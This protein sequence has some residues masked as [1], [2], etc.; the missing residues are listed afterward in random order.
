[1]I[2]SNLTSFCTQKWHHHIL[3]WHHN[4]QVTCSWFL[5]LEKISSPWKYGS[6]INI[7]QH[8]IV[9]PTKCIFRY[10]ELSPKASSK[11]AV[12]FQNSWRIDCAECWPGNKNGRIFRQIS[13]FT[14]FK[15]NA[16][17]NRLIPLTRHFN[18]LLSS[19]EN[20]SNYITLDL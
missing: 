4:R 6:S 17:N 11:K 3:C 14:L 7:L 2:L 9:L 8:L 10:F 15:G 12:F 5:S 16:N 20:L 19:K 13:W 1:M 18:R